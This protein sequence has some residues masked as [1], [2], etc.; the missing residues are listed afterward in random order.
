MSSLGGGIQGSR[1]G[2]GFCNT[3]FGAEDAMKRK[4]LRKV[5]KPNKLTVNGNKVV[6]TAGPFRTAL[7]QGDFLSRV[8][9]SC[10]GCNQVNDVN[11]K[12]LRQNMIDSISNNNCDTVTLGVT[13][14]QIPLYYGNHKY[15]SDSSLYT[16]FKNLSATN[17][18]YNDS[19]FGGD[20]HNG[21]Y[22]FLMKVRGN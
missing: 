6:S 19:S 16:K 17:Q 7:S 20:S 21:S 9:Q 22:T 3:T 5:L 11:S 4:I 1:P 18:N 15:V 12:V 10:G 8:G 2:I 14:K 13:P